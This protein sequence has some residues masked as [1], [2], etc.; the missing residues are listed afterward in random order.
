MPDGSTQTLTVKAGKKTRTVNIHFLM[1]WVQHDKAKLQEPS[2]A[3][4]LLVMLRG[5]FE[6]TQAIDLRKYDRMVLD[7]VKK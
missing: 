7:A 1:N 4:R 6:D 2:R 5:W 3:V